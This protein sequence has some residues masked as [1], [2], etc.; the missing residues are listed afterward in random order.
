MEAQTILY[1]PGPP[2]DGW[3]SGWKIGFK[4]SQDYLCRNQTQP[5]LITSLLQLL[6]E[7]LK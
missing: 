1:K 3:V 4:I 7:F 5:W 6:D 2:I